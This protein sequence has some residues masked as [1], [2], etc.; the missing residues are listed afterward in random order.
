MGIVNRRNAMLGWLVW[1]VGKQ[2][3]M[4][5]A[6]AAI[7]TDSKR[8]NTPVLVLGLGLPAPARWPTGGSAAAATT[9]T[10]SGRSWTT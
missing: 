3:A 10:R 1:N 4:R 2:V 7:D 6:K 8:P 9:R 5:K